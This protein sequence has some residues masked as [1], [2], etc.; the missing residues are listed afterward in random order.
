LKV[1]EPDQLLEFGG[2]GGAVHHV[3]LEHLAGHRC[4]G[5][6]PDQAALRFS[7]IAELLRKASTDVAITTSLAAPT[8]ETLK[9]HLSVR[10]PAALVRRYAGGELVA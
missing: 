5:D 3:G 1:A 9:P 8:V 7:W 2:G 10:D 6:Q 4:R